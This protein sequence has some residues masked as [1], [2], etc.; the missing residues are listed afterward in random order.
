MVALDERGQPVRGLAASDF[1]LK[2]DGRI[3]DVDSFQEVSA[4]GAGGR[5]DGRTLLLILDDSGVEPQLTTRI[6]RSH[7]WSWRAWATPTP[8]ASCI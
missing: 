2:E 5:A 8:C 3:V 6:Q 7:A 1:T 4:L